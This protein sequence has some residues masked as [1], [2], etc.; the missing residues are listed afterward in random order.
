MVTIRRR[1]FTEDGPREVAIRE[2]KLPF[3]CAEKIDGT[4]IFFL[5]RAKVPASDQFIQYAILSSLGN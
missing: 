5:L 2:Y 3:R 4:R 1:I